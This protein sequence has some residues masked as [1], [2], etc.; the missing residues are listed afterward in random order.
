MNIYHQSNCWEHSP[1]PL[2]K[3]LLISSCVGRAQ[4]TGV[5]ARRW[6]GPLLPWR[7]DL[8]DHW[9][10]VPAP[11]CSLETRSGGQVAILQ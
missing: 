5:Q 4:A 8:G 7:V 6:A 1:L 9:V 3:L 10:T 2:E 11:F